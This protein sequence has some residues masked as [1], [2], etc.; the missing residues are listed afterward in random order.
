MILLGSLLLASGG[1]TAAGSITAMSPALKQAAGVLAAALAVSLI[2][3]LFIEPVATKLMFQRYDL[4]NLP[5]KTEAVKAEIAGLYK[6]FGKFHGISALINLIV[7]SCAFAHVSFT[8]D[9]PLG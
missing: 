9:S 2:N 3:W 1:G 4:E 8:L 7:L 6:Q 5:E